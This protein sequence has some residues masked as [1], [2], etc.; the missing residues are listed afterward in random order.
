MDVSN[1][2]KRIGER[3]CNYFTVCMKDD[4][5]DDFVLVHSPD[6]SIPTKCI[7]QKQTVPI[8]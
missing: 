5:Y 3:E 1:A 8:R 2:I 4:L 6:S 7:S